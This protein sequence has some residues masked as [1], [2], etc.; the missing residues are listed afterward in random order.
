MVSVKLVWRL[1]TLS[2]FSLWCHAQHQ[3]IDD[4]LSFGLGS[5]ASGEFTKCH[6]VPYAMQRQVSAWSPS[7]TGLSL[8]CCRSENSSG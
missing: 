5:I 8:E 2:R 1:C 3:A 4:N 7:L 6:Y